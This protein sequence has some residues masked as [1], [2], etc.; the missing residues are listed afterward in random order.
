ME[1]HQLG[2]VAFEDRIDKL[3]DAGDMVD[4]AALTLPLR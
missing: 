1:C 2:R 4:I 3:R